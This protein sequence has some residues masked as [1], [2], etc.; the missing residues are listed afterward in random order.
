MDELGYPISPFNAR[1]RSLGLLTMDPVMK[2][3]S[4]FCA[5]EAYVRDTH[6][7]AAVILTLA[8]ITLSALKGI[9]RLVFI[10][11]VIDMRALGCPSLRRGVMQNSM[12]L[13]MASGSFFGMD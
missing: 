6:G 5:L 2:G 13:E 12:V 1:F 4:N 7:D 10:D 3:C 8:F 9:V 11:C